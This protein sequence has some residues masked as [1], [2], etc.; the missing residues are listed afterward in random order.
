MVQEETAL[1]QDADGCLP[2]M[3]LRSVESTRSERLTPPHRT[4]IHS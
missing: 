2:S 3:E 1:Q 4:K